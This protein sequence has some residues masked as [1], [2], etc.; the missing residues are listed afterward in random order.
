MPLITGIHHVSLLV[1]DTTRALAFYEGVLGLSRDPGRRVTRYAGAWLQVGALQIHLIEL[2]SP[3]PVDGR[4]S[5][6]GDDRHTA[7]AVSDLDELARRLTA[8]GVAYTRS[9]SGRPA[10]FCRDPDA[11]ALEFIGIGP[12]AGAGPGAG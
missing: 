10:L 1:R 5:H 12:A 8:A 6:G 7:L 2:P 3:D 9:G 11:N 4:P